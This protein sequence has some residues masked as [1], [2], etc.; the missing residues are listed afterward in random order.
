MIREDPAVK[1][2]GALLIPSDL[3]SLFIGVGNYDSRCRVLAR[4]L[5]ALLAVDWR[6]VVEFEGTLADS[7]QNQS[8]YKETE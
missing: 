5:S 1:E 3:I 4:Q 7:V 2:N 6:D 8:R